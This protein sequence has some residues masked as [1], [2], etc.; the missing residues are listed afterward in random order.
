M[1]TVLIETTNDEESLAR[2]LGSLVSAAVEGVVRDVIVCDHGSSDQTH[3]VAEHA[4]C[5][6][7][8][9]GGVA[10][11]IRQ[12]KGEWI[13][14]IEPGAKLGEGWTNAVVEH[15]ATSR[16]AAR[17]SPSAG[18]RRPFLSR[19]FRRDR[20]LANALVITKKQAATLSSKASDSAAIARGVSPR[21]L[22]AEISVAP[23]RK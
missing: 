7:V 3:R 8:A 18:S 15:I 21:R 6:L 22:E 2:T 4:G 13:L 10:A 14:L 19:L 23:A 9:S 16:V 20:P 1:L 12:A 17:F 5:H 11:G